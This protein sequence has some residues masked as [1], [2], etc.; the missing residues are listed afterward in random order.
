MD[1]SLPPRRKG[2]RFGSGV[3]NLQVRNRLEWERE[4]RKKEAKKQ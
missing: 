4:K 2:M 1:D 3:T